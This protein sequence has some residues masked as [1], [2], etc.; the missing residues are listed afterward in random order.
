MKRLCIGTL[1][2]NIC[3]QLKRFDYDWER[4]EAIKFNDYFQF[5][6]QLDMRPYTADGIDEPPGQAQAQ[7]LYRLKVSFKLNIGLKFR[8]G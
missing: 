2:P 1:P 5:P 6:R 3:I 4:E 7:N 8:Y